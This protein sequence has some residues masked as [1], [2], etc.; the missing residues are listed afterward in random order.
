[1]ETGDLQFH[2]IQSINFERIESESKFSGAL[3]VQGVA[4]LTRRMRMR[5]KEAGRRRMKRRW[6]ALLGIVKRGE[7]ILGKRW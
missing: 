4:F 1:M 6:R 2:I 5:R 3:L 7:D